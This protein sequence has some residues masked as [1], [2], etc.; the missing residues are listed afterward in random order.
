M[1]KEDNASCI[2]LTH[3]EGTIV[4]MIHISLNRH[5]FKDHIKAGDIKVVKI[6]SAFNWAEMFTIPLCR[7]KHKNLHKFIMGW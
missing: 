6:D 1:V 4:C 7:P 2:I 3:G 5:W